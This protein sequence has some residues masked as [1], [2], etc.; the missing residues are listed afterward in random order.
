M[1]HPSAELN[2][3]KNNLRNKEDFGFAVLGKSVALVELMSR[4][5]KTGKAALNAFE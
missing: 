3:F 4:I 5:T 2:K 1:I